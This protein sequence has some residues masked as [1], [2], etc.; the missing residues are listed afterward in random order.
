[1]ENGGVAAPAVRSAD[2]IRSASA[3]TRASVQIAGQ[4][5]ATHNLVARPATGR[6]IEKTLLLQP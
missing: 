5:V 2:R 4:A 3:V 1:M 6:E